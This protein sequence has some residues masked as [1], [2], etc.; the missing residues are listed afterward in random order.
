MEH[1]LDLNIGAQKRLAI[2]KK[3]NPQ[4][5]RKAR[6]STFKTGANCQGFNDKTTHIWYYM[7][8]ETPFRDIKPCH[9]VDT[10]IRHT[11]WWCDDYQD[12]K[13]FGIVGSLSHGRFMAGYELTMNDEHVFFAELFTDASEAA[14]MADEHARV[15][16]DQE[17]EHNVRWNEA[18]EIEE[19]IERKQSK[20]CELFDIRNEKCAHWATHPRKQIARIIRDIRDLTRTLE[21]DYAGVI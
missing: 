14:Q 12:S 6:Y 9:D 18:R 21:T 10:S 1:Y 15:I 11:G 19:K 7:S 5:W 17:M 3:K 8:Q 2:L 20:L 4:D 13:A 16:A